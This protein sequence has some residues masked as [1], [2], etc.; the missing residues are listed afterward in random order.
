ME[1]PHPPRIYTSSLT[2]PPTK[3]LLNDYLESGNI[4]SLEGCVAPGCSG[5][6]DDYTGFRPASVGAQSQH[7]NLD[8]G[9]RPG[10]GAHDSDGF[11]WL[12]PLVV[13]GGGSW[14]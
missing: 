3:F 11:A 14:A 8:R 4:L 13:R 5:G 1:K 9:C 2:S 7:C 6:R 12:A 10:G